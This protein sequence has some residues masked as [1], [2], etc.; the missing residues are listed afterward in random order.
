MNGQRAAALPVRF[1]A[2]FC[3]LT[4]A[5]PGTA[6]PQDARVGDAQTRQVV[7]LTMSVGSMEKEVRRVV[8]APP[9]GW[10]VR[11]HRVDCTA[12]YG[13][14]SYTVNTVP[15]DWTWSSE[16]GAAELAR[17]KVAAAVRAHGV[18]AQVQVAHASDRSFAERQRRTSSHHA[19]VVEA[20]AQGAGLF[21]GGGGL[22][23]T[24]TAELVYIGRD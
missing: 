23:L 20:T 9:P 4:A 13:L 3:A 8:Y 22:E 1:V 11:S 16:E 18:P 17:A 6:R 15:A 2:T 7:S 10:Y 19:L 14:S 12:R 5:V 21:R 24:V